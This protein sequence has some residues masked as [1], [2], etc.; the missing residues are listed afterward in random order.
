MNAPTPP[1]QALAHE[2]A[3]MVAFFDQLAKTPPTDQAHEQQQFTDVFLPAFAAYCEQGS[4]AVAL[5]IEQLI[6]LNY[7]KRWEAEAHFRQTY[8]ALVPPLRRVAERAAPDLA[9]LSERPISAPA[10]RD[11]APPLVFF[12]IHVE[13]GLA[14]IQSLLRYLESMREFAADLPPLQPVVVS[15]DG[16]DAGLR[17]RLKALQVPLVALGDHEPRTAKAYVKLIKFAALCHDHQPQAI[18]FVSLVMWMASFFA[19]RLAKTQVWWAMK[20]HAFSSPDIDGYMCG[21]PD[22]QPR[23]LG[24]NHWETSPFGGSDWFASELRAEAAAERARLGP[25]KTVFGSIGREEKLRDPAFLDAV[26]GVLEANPESVFLWTGARQDAVIQS[27]FAARGLAERTRFIGWVNTRLYA[28][29]IDVYLDSFP[30]PGGYTVYEAMAARRPV[31]MMKLAYPSVGLQNNASPYY[32]ATDAAEGVSADVQALFRKADGPIY[33]P[34]AANRDDYIAYASRFAQEPS[35]HAEVGRIN[36]EFVERF[37]SNRQG[38]AAGY[39]H[40][41]HKFIH[42]RM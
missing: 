3:A 5:D 9:R 22:G 23:T 32:F 4:P 40:A 17:Q 29:V 36:A 15:L 35:L 1:A 31:V 30:F 8:A 2:M 11:D 18:V 26:C 6:Y 33:Y 7:V 21:S 24:G 27:F 42:Q 16:A 39:H 10:R 19:A 25:W 28:Q 14:H 12:V 38:M 13:S 20:Y 34:V 37:M 41:L